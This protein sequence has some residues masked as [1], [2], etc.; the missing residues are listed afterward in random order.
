MKAKFKLIFFRIL[1]YSID[2]LCLFVLTIL[3]GILLNIPNTLEELVGDVLALFY[4][5]YFHKKSGQTVG[6]KIL[7]IKVVDKISGDLI[8]W[9]QSIF[10][11]L[12]W[13]FLIIIDIII[14]LF[15]NNIDIENDY[16]NNYPY[17]L[18][19]VIL[20]SIVIDN[21]SRGLHDRIAGTLVI[22]AQK[23]LE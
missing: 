7:Y 22:D 4:F 15:S 3:M 20:I 19:V 23:K 10:R 9:K 6:K 5:I 16:F 13:V 12:I 17:I 11:E 18:N 14:I 8:S 1:A 2:L 21:N